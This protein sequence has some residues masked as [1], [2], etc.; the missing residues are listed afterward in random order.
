MAHAFCSG[1]KQ[2]CLLGFK[3]APRLCTCVPHASMCT[4][5]EFL[6]AGMHLALS[7]LHTACSSEAPTHLLGQARSHGAQRA[8]AWHRSLSNA[9]Y[10][11]MG[12]SSNKDL[13]CSL[14]C[15]AIGPVQ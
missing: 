7:T 8:L 4:C 11:A 6:L 12:G 15:L 3:W 2:F 14:L 13:C 10:E 9:G 5:T 1:I